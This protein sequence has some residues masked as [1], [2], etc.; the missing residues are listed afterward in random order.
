MKTPVNPFITVGYAGPEWFCDRKNETDSILKSIIN[1]TPVTITS[2]RRMGKTGLIRHVLTQ[3]PKNY[4]GIY[5]DIQP[6]E[7][8]NDFMNILAT[9]MIRAVPE[10]SKPGKIFWNFIKSL[11]PVITFEQLSGL[12]QVSIATITSKAEPDIESVFSFLERQPFRIIVAIDE[13]QQILQFHEKSTDAWLRSKIQQLNNLTFIFSGSQQHMMDE[14]FNSPSKPF[15]RIT[16]FMRIKKIPFEEYS[17]FICRLF[18]QGDR[19]ISEEVAGQILEWG[20]QITYYIQL[21]CNRIYFSGEKIISRSHWQSEAN[22]LIKEMEPVF[23]GYRDLL[24]IP[25]WM[26]LKALATEGKVNNPTSGKFI[27]NFNLSGSATV[28]LSLKA[29]IKKDLVYKD[30]DPEGHALYSVN[31][32]LFKHWIQSH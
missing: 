16:N 31:D 26:L 29:L 19:K 23:F 2:I 4:I 10:K 28:I 11:R 1:G 18:H 22:K 32:L 3:I 30:F 20:E 7:N 17:E 8:L 15:Y 14:L 27:R 25:Q 12:P 21:L 9:A 13:F 24:T 6:S 5:L